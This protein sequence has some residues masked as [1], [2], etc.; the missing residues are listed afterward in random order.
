MK[1][2]SKGIANFIAVGVLNTLVGYAIY[3]F[4][5]LLGISYLLALLIA[6]IAGVTFNYF[7]IGRLV[8]KSKGGLVIFSKFV[9]AYGCVY[10]TN[11]ALLD[12]FVRHFQ[13]GPYI[14]QALCIPLSVL[15]S[16]ILMN[17]WVY[18]NNCHDEK[19]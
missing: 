18:K 9:A 13:T 11:A 7:S 1:P 3:I 8:F 2:L 5:I 10:F 17:F 6:T 14:G 12:V 16:W 4:L 19:N 15:L